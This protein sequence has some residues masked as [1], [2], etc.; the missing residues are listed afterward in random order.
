MLRK[1]FLRYLALP[2][3]QPFQDI[4]DVDA[5]T[6]RVNQYTYLKDPW[7]VRS[8]VWSR[9][10]PVALVRRAFGLHNPGDGGSELM[11]EGFRFVDIG[12][13]RKL[14]KGIEESNRLSGVAYTKASANACPF[15]HSLA[16]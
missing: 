10:G 11:P 12:P 3:L 4:S 6:G 16:T 1:L 7:Y 5:V 14:G 2:R 9:W 13:K 15:A 8:S